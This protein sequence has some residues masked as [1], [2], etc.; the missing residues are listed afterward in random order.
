MVVAGCEGNG[1]IDA[2]AASGATS[3]AEVRPELSHADPRLKEIS[4]EAG[5][6]LPG[7]REA[8]DRRIA[9][10]KGLPIVVN[11]WGSWCGP[12]RA[13]FPMFQDAAKDLGGEI[14][15]LGV[16][17]SDS[18]EAA[19]EFLRERPVPYPSYVDD[20]LEIAK[21]LPPLQGAPTTGFYNAAGELTHV[22]AGEY[23]TAKQLR[24]DIR[25]YAIGADS[26]I[27][28]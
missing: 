17:V 23:R 18:V 20:K 24:N 21:L 1:N 11:K 28:R 3:L 19:G 8:Y 9:K 14:A 6:L 12:C 27:A 10:L 13:E 4:A 7:G 15:F 26:R 22:K 25:D 16:N 2:G 5:K